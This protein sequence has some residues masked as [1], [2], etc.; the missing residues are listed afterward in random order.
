MTVGDVIQAVARDGKGRDAVMPC[1]HCELKVT[2]RCSMSNGGIDIDIFHIDPGCEFAKSGALRRMV[3][4]MFTK[5]S[6]S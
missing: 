3:Q 4:S 2:L 1:P 5:G 6:A